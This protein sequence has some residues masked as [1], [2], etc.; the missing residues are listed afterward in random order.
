MNYQER[1]EVARKTKPGDKW[2]RRK[3][4]IVVDVVKVDYWIR[5]LYPSGKTGTISD[6]GLASAY[7]PCQEGV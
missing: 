1:C 2:K 7:E 3:D 6:N 5:L 4:G